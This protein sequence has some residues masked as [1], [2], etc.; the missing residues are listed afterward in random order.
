MKTAF[1]KVFLISTILSI[2]T[3]NINGQNIYTIAGNGSYGSSGDGGTATNA[4]LGRPFGI[5][6]D[7]TG[8]LYIADVYNHRIRM[9]T[10]SG[11]IT[12]IAG[13]GIA[14]FSGDG[15]AAI[16]AELNYP[17]GVAL[18]A[19]GNILIVDQG[20]NRIRKINTSGIISTIAGNGS[21]FSGDGGP[22]ISAGLAIPYG[23]TVDGGGNIYITEWNSRVRKINTSGIITTIAGN[24]TV[25]FSGD[26][27]PATSAQL[28]SPSG[29][30]VD[31]SGNIYIVDNSNNRVRKINTSG[32]I[33]TIAG[34]GTIGF[35]GDGGQGSLAKLKSP[36]GVTTDATGN[37]YVTD[38]AN[39]RIRKID[40]SGI[41]STF[42]G[43]G[44]AGFSGDGGAAISAQ[45]SGP[46]GV[47][48]DG[49][50]NLYISEYVNNRIRKVCSGSC[51]AGIN[52]FETY[53]NKFLIF[54]NPNNGTFNFQIDNEIKN[55]EFILI[56]SLG[57]KVY[58]QKISQGQNKI[59]TNGLASGLYNY[60][61]LQ[62][63]GQISSGKLTVQ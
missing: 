57:Q 14:G 4:E 47:A 53:T 44:G 37:I 30:A 33:S 46:Q 9:V 34:D 21:G 5:A 40:N 35:S 56:N 15:A 8:N 60:I 48:A 10:A 22:A 18:D 11:I 20:N 43:N 27:G 36:F 1:F 52:S 6:V 19:S 13:N 62:D 31:L 59:I 12:T 7:G 50:G 26:G 54:P 24:G 55:A 39:S 58:E 38:Y 32:I 41:I 63:K 49:S 17:I 2:T 16:S 28:S 23:I 42:A 51:L 45:I 25:G 3:N 61:I 29:V